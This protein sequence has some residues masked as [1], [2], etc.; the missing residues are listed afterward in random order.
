MH[1]RLQQFRQTDT[2]FAYKRSRTQIVALAVMCAAII[3]ATFLVYPIEWRPS[4]HFADS[5][6]ESLQLGSS[7]AFHGSFS[8]PFFRLQT[9]PSAH[10]APGY[11]AI[12]ALVIKRF[13]DG[14][15]AD[16]AL[17][18]ITVIVI[19]LRLALLPLLADY[20]G[21]LPWTGLLAAMAAL[22]SRPPLL[23]W[24]NDFAT[25]LI[26]LLSFPMYRAF[27]ARLSA[28]GIFCTGLLW[29]VLLLFTPSP[30]LVLAAW[31]FVLF[32]IAPQSRRELALLAL[33]PGLVVL[34]WLV[35]NYRVFHKPVFL[36]DNLGIELAVSNNDCAQ[37]SMVLNMGSSGCFDRNHPNVSLKEAW[38]V[39][40]LGEAAYNQV[41]LREARTWINHNRAR[42]LTLSAKRFMA[43]WFPNTTE[44]LLRG[45]PVLDGDWTTDLLTLLSIPGLFLIWR[46]NRSAAMLFALWLFFL[47]P[48]Y[49][50]IQYS[51]R[52]RDPI[53]P[54]TSLPAAYVIT[55][56]A[57]YVALNAGRPWRRQA[58][59]AD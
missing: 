49:Y 2:S 20:L 59:G 34:P 46:R 21:L 55:A 50:L 10:L 14:P 52:Y 40:T 25:L 18:W 53:M 23:P 17:Q 54:M 26:V 8:D 32:L 5:G 29:G 48:V 56:A 15:S 30:L 37:F 3:L 35:R 42:F 47:P 58:V 22:W 51:P 1:L 6:F 36:R 19:A 16:Y 57:L 13:G 41:R 45:F 33:I 11:P 28:T 7:L 39:R 24:E 44:N 4:H 31:L 38:R 12:V 27:R 43:F 9:G